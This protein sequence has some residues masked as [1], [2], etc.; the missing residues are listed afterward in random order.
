MAKFASITADLLARKG[1]ARPWAYNSQETVLAEV[2]PVMFGHA[3][4]Q[5]I[6]AQPSLEGG[7]RLA[8]R[9]SESDYECLGLIAA[10][11]DVSRQVLLR[12]ILDGFLAEAAEEHRG[13]CGCIGSSCRR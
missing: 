13:R 1:E 3:E 7:R 12:E 8:L 9:L 6:H 11:R 10:K 4:H 2:K 5:E